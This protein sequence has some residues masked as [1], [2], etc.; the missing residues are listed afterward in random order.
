MDNLQLQ[1]QKYD[2]IFNLPKRYREDVWDIC[3]WDYYKNADSDY[4]SAWRVR[5]NVMNHAVDFTLCS[6]LLVREELKFFFYSLIEEKKIVLVSFSEYMDKYKLLY[7]Y[8]NE[9]HI[10][11]ILD[12]QMDDYA[13]YIS[14][15]HK[16]QTDNGTALSKG[17]KRVKTKKQNRLITFIKS[18]QQTLV[19]YYEKNKSLLERDVWYGRD[20]EPDG[21]KCN[22]SFYDI[23]QEPMKI[24]IKRFLK[25][26]SVSVRISTL[27]SYLHYFK[28]FCHWMETYDASIL[29]FNSINRNILE[30][31]FQYLRL[32]SGFSQNK[33]FYCIFYLSI[34]FDYGILSDSD[35]FP[36]ISLFTQNDYCQ[37]TKRK[38]NF[39]E[40]EDI[41][42]IFRE[43]IPKLPKVYGR[44]ILILFLTGMRISELLTLSPS[45]LRKESGNAYFLD[46]YMRKT[47][48]STAIPIDENAFHLLE[49]EVHKNQ[50]LFSNTDYIFLKDT[51]KPF[52]YS[53]FV[54]V[55]KSAIVDNNITGKDGNLLDFRTHRFRAT[56]ATKLINMGLDP[57]VAAD[58][59]GQSTLT[60]LSYY[61]VAT[62]Q[63]LQE[64]MQS[65]LKKQSILINNIGKIDDLVLE[66]YKNAIPLCNG[67]C[68]KPPELGICEKAN[69]CISCSQFKPSS[70]FLL[71]YKLQLADIKETLVVASANG[72]TRLIE[73]C[74][75][76]K[77]Y[78][79]KIITAV[80]E[81][82]NE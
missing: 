66:D 29:S 49:S 30:D 40:D 1:F 72:Y 31:Y 6:A 58:M 82:V 65:Y 2:N 47:K 13:K 22:L 56:K 51:G 41:S 43:L 64:Q 9:N 37:K 4:Q 55:I 33:I 27:K 61:A 63:V 18:I 57:T 39:Y 70:Q 79:E 53:A 76:E 5:S 46:I 24:A 81:K 77:S 42:I 12:I 44:M 15:N 35:N 8:V 34:L 50:Q 73:K 71:N 59:L 25:I 74:E 28:A 19:S 48:K 62:K 60:A 78:L 11:S 14:A 45:A 26:K 75:R 68:C 20:I 16:L 17:K 23:K 80:E 67:W 7:K 3:E 21:I 54:K 38:E 32:E 52:S 69:A 36:K 10:Q